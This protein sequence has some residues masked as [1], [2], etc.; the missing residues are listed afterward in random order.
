M[1]PI[2]PKLGVAIGTALVVALLAVGL[3]VQSARLEAE[4]KSHGATKQEYAAFVDKVKLLGEVAEK[5]AR[6]E[7]A[8]AKID[9]EA[10]D[11]ENRD[12]R[13]ELDVRRGQLRDERARARSSIVPAPGAASERPDRATFDRA[14]LERGIQQDLDRAEGQ[15]EALAGKGAAAVT[16][17]NT[18]RKWAQ[19]RRAQ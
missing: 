14:E 13:R 9:K 1:I 16:D 15:L 3:W 7:T 10:A 6:T 12:L 18:A 2:T 5:A 19:K 8:R 4:Q 17:L 11:A